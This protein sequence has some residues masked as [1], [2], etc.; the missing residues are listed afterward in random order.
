[1][2]TRGISC[3]IVLF[4]VSSAWA[5]GQSA[6][7]SLGQAAYSNNCW[8]ACPPGP[9]PGDTSYCRASAYSV[10]RSSMAVGYARGEG[11]YAT[12]TCRA[13]SY[14]RRYCPRPYRSGVILG[15]CMSVNVG[16]GHSRARSALYMQIQSNTCPGTPCRPCPQPVMTAR[17]SSSLSLSLGGYRG[18][19]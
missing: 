11:G 3:L 12:A 1:M 18:C 7:C 15:A 8:N 6:Y 16:T 17:I 19:F 5:T 2:G 13:Q 10:G 9:C 4:L 14:G